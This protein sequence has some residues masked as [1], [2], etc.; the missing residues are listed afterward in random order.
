MILKKNLLAIVILFAGLL[1]E[2][3]V[4][5]PIRSQYQVTGKL[6]VKAKIEAG[7]TIELYLNSDFTKSYQQKIVSNEINEYV[8][9]DIPARI[10]MMRVDLTDHP[11][12]KVEIHEISLITKNVKEALPIGSLSGWQKNQVSLAASDQ[13]KI[14]FNTSGGD[15]FIHASE[16]TLGSELA[17]SQ[18]GL[19]NFMLYNLWIILAVPAL[20]F[21][22]INYISVMM[23]VYPAL[24]VFLYYLFT[25][26]IFTYIDSFHFAL[27]NPSSSV[28]HAL[29]MGYPKVSEQIKM[30]SAIFLSIFAALAFSALN[31]YTSK[32]LPHTASP[33]RENF[34]TLGIWILGLIFIALNFPD[35]RYYTNILTGRKLP[36]A[37][38]DS[39]NILTW[40]YLAQQGFLPY[41]DY[42]F[43]YGGDYMEL[44]FSNQ[45]MLWKFAEQIIIFF[46]VFC[47]VFLLLNNSLV[48]TAFVL[49][50]LGLLIDRG[51]LLGTKRYLL[52]LTAPLLFYAISFKAEKKVPLF[53]I[54]GIYLAWCFTQDASQLVF[55]SIPLSLVLIFSFAEHYKNGSMKLL[56]RNLSLAGLGFLIT[57]SIYFFNLYR[58]Q[59][60]ASY[61]EFYLNLGT[62]TVAAAVPAT[63]NSWLEIKWNW[64]NILFSGTILLVFMSV[65][66]LSAS[67]N[68]S[69]RELGKILSLI[70]LAIIMVYQKMLVRPHM[71]QQVIVMLYIGACFYLYFLAVNLPRKAFFVLLF[72]IGV[73]SGRLYSEL[74]LDIYFDDKLAQ[75]KSVDERL[76]Y[77]F[78]NPRTQKEVMDNYY[79]NANLSEID[80]NN[81]SAL[82]YLGGKNLSLFATNIYVL[83]DQS[84]Y[85]V[86]LKQKP[87]PYISLYDN[88]GIHSQNE[89]VACLKERLP[90]Y[91]IWDSSKSGFDN[92]PNLVRVPLIFDHIIAN[93]VHETSFGTVHILHSSDSSGKFDWD[94][95]INNLTNAIDLGA[96]PWVSNVTKFEECDSSSC[97]SFAKLSNSSSE[98]KLI[99]ENREFTIQT[100]RPDES[101]VRISSSPAVFL[102]RLWFYNAAKRTGKTVKVMDTQNSQELK[103]ESKNNLPNILY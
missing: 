48:A 64:D 71:A 10:R 81:R 14:V 85:Y 84:Y 68:R 26:P 100:K 77:A 16:L 30:F 66:L 62:I 93:Y 6:M 96:I 32:T 98:L 59:Q 43:P 90:A 37:G 31:R 92:V 36:F 88:S 75:I 24:F 8:F 73:L 49:F 28:G 25:P 69:I 60:L 19:L 83:G 55:A 38:F 20:I 76:M 3:T 18:G 44:G 22:A 5:L 91:V 79:S 11:D 12:T 45:S 47:S 101:K 1:L 103:I 102:N 87:C 58:N 13:D 17:A 4:L 40:D 15:P 50:A 27:Q 41:K 35:L 99:V 42:W 39:S 65:F 89:Q 74:N 57:I 7:S 80:E 78:N 33:P 61:F 34:S 53:T 95:W 51:I 29:F 86:A 23:L 2:I 9:S 70:S 72:L 56:F 82:D 97:V 46:A 52:C 63:I 21:I 67:M 54:F 94:F